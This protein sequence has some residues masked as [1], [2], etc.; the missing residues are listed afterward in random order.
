MLLTRINE[1]VDISDLRN[2]LKSAVELEKLSTKKT[3]QVFNLK[4]IFDNKKNEKP[5]IKSVKP[6]F[7]SF[8]LG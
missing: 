8:N 7:N 2:E 6:S 1:N 3:V 5:V 4:V